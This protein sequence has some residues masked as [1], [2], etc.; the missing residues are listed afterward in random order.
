M[1]VLVAFGCRSQN[2]NAETELSVPVSVLEIKPAS[3]SKYI[4]T[5]GTV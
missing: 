2:Q 3:I 1:T 5:S 4:N